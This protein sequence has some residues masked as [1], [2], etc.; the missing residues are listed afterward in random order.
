M[1]WVL[2]IGVH[3]DHRVATGVDQVG[4]HRGFF[5][6]VAAEGDVGNPGVLLAQPPNR[7]ARAVATAVINENN[8]D[9]DAGRL[10]RRQHLVDQLGQH[11]LLVIARHHDR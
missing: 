4:Q 7:L 3:D 10:Q 1:R 2:Q 5:A 9:V 11:I 8:L 6:E